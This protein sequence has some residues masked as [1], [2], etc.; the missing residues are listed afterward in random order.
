L[1]AAGHRRAWGGGA[2]GWDFCFFCFFNSRR[3]SDKENKKNKNI[4]TRAYTEGAGV[5]LVEAA[6][7]GPGG[8]HQKHDSPA[9]PP[10]CTVPGK[11]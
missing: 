9:P 2:V 8:L 3:K 5:I 10:P 11:H 6:F 7:L 1:V 4:A